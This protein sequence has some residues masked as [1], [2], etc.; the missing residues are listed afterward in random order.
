MRQQCP[1]L[2][3]FEPG[4][5]CFFGRC[6]L[7]ASSLLLVWVFE[8]TIFRK[9]AFL[10]WQPVPGPGP[11]MLVFGKHIYSERHEFTLTNRI[12]RFLAW[13]MPY[14]V[15]HHTLPNV[16]FHKLPALH[17]HMQGRH[18]VLSNGYA[19]FTADYARHLN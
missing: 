11:A 12:I 14:H 10:T 3:K 6:P 5:Q 15:E 7:Q 2:Q 4:F 18:R 1:Q 13:N 8:L 17:D 16:P 19:E 9:K